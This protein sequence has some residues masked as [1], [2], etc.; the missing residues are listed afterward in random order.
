MMLK[1]GVFVSNRLKLKVTKFRS[2]CNYSLE[3]ILKNVVGG[4]DSARPPL[5][6]IGLREQRGSCPHECLNVSFSKFLDNDVTK[7]S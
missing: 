6:G 7:S 5:V 1:F 2:Y 3:V 4:A